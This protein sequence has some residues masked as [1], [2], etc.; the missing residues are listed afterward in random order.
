MPSNFEGFGKKCYCILTFH[1]QRE[2]NHWADYPLDKTKYES[3][4]EQM[5]RYCSILPY[6]TLVPTHSLRT[7][8][9]RVL[10]SANV[11]QRGVIHCNYTREFNFNSDG[12]PPRVLP[13]VGLLAGCFGFC[14]NFPR[15][16]PSR[17]ST[18]PF[19]TAHECAVCATFS[20]GPRCVQCASQSGNRDT[21]KWR[22]GAGFRFSQSI[23][24]HF[25][26][27]AFCPV[28]SPF[29]HLQPCVST[30]YC[31]TDSTV[32]WMKKLKT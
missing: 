21:R 4:Q 27:R 30:I 10:M 18:D 11:Q 25:P 19:E 13:P 20:Y 7:H 28:P 3:R 9:L 31:C 6:H 24:A 22:F 32:G 23:D 29:V 12:P 15:W 2:I 14:Q 1:S 26:A 17:L 16:M 8:L 5:I